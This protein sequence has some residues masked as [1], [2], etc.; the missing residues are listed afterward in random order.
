VV[1]EANDIVLQYGAVP[2][3]A[4]SAVFPR[5]FDRARLEVAGTLRATVENRDTAAGR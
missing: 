4:L 2:G 5:S 3:R 1:R